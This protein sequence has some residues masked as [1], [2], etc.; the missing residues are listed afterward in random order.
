MPP[1]SKT[2]GAFPKDKEKK[3]EHETVKDVTLRIPFFSKYKSAHDK[4]NRD[5]NLYDLDSIY[6]DRN[7]RFKIKVQELTYYLSDLDPKEN[8]EKTKVYYSDDDF[9]TPTHLGQVLFDGDYKIDDKEIVKYKTNDPKK[10]DKRE[11]PRIQLK[12]DKGFFQKKIL[13][14]EGDGELANKRRFNNYF[15]GLYISTYGFNKNVLMLLDFNNADIKI[16]YTYTSIDPNDKNKLVEK[17]RDLTLRVGGI[18]FN[19]F[20]KSKETA[21]TTNWAN[22]NPIFLSGGQGY[23]SEIEIDESGLEK[24]KKSGDLINEANLTFKIDR[25]GMQ[26]LGYN[27]EPKR[28][29]LF[30]LNNGKPLIDY[31]TQA[32]ATDNSYLSVGGKLEN[33]ENGEDKMYKIR[34]TN[35]LQSIVSKDSTNVKLGLSIVSDIH[36]MTMLS[37]ENMD[38]EKIRIPLQM[39]INP[40]ATI[41]YGGSPSV[42]KDK[43][44]RLEIYKSS[45]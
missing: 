39:V 20:K 19:H 5:G 3:D 45:N 21:S 33:S 43:R 12:L 35:H 1:S 6:G 4:L 34:I 32:N 24:L 44:L 23:Y 10:V 29:Y 31:V 25:S 28:L 40:F 27:Q 36:S 2:F 18:T 17:T 11:P 9:S 7:A 41:L 42:V 38:R 15:K 22:K 8:L 30:N 14:K 26:S 37:A 13:D 16:E